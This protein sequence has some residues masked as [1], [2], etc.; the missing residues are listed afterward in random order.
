MEVN[1]IAAEG[2][3]VVLERG[4]LGR[5]GCS[6]ENQPYVFPIHFF[7]RRWLPVL[8]LDIWVGRIVLLQ[9]SSKS[10]S[11]AWAFSRVHPMG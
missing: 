5:L 6:H 1:E 7:L 3:Q 11:C 10:S 4:L 9:S 2:C 8:L